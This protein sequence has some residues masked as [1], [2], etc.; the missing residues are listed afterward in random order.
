M[1]E[2]LKGMR[3]IE[4]ASFI[5][6]PSCGLH[7]AQMGAEV[8]R[9][10]DIRG[11]PDSGRWPLSPNGASFYWE[12]LNKGKKSIALDLS[13][14]EGRELAMRLATAPGANAGF[15]LTNFPAAGFLSHERLS[16]LRKDLITLRVMGWADERPAVDYTVNSALGIP[17]MTGPV[18]ETGPVN[19]VLPAWDLITGAYAAFALLAADRDRARTGKG[20]EIR[21]PLGDLAIATLGHLGQI[22][23]VTISGVDR[24]RMGNELFGAFGRD[25]VTKDGGRIMLVAITKRQWTGLIAALG[26]ESEIAS[27]EKELGVSFLGD[28]GARFRH[29]DRLMP[30]VEKGIGALPRGEIVE[31]FDKHG[32]CWDD[33]R[34]L[35][36]ALAAD[37]RVSAQNPLLARVMHPSGHEYLTPG[38]AASIASAERLSPMRAPR[39]GE[40]TDEIL[41]E[42]L[43][44]TNREIGE[45]HDSGLVA[46]ETGAAP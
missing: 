15:F 4:G 34:T 28:E 21:V 10:D 41:A 18:R 40:H 32:V 27:L 12:G 43:H 7:L 36:E 33:F 14:P 24:P 11:G 6:G 44:L 22:A 29:R 16:A 37:P 31:R 19:H 5:A 46:A 3:V 26:L 9:F 39:L 1:Y 38:A 25:F 8:I 17:F 30:L 23:E 13:R 45:L 42:V 2:L 20:C 35:G